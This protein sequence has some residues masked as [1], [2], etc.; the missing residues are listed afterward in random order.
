MQTHLAK[1]DD[2]FT[3][4]VPL[5][6]NHKSWD[7]WSLRGGGGCAKHPLYPTHKIPL[8]GIELFSYVS[9]LYLCHHP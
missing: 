6:H 8:Q 5:G 7:C 9:E 1:R 4:V 2:N 3:G